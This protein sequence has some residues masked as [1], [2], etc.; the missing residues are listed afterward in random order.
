MS[1]SFRSTD[2]FGQSRQTLRYGEWIRLAKTCILTAS[3]A[4]I[5]YVCRPIIELHHWSL[6][7]EAT[8]NDQL[9]G[10]SEDSTLARDLPTDDVLTSF[11]LCISSSYNDS[12]SYLV[13]VESL[14]K[15]WLDRKWMLGRI[16]VL[17]RCYVR[18]DA[19]HDIRLNRWR[20]LSSVWVHFVYDSCWR[21]Y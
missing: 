8:T 1:C 15:K 10:N 19:V 20:C 7:N 17:G 12:K 3:K 9:Y 4:S 18:C 21:S 13:F 11:L 16:E 6:T 2:S 5:N 14:K